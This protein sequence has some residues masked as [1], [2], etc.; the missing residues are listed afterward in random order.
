[1]INNLFLCIIVF[2]IVIYIIN[3][4]KNK[5]IFEKFNVNTPKIDPNFKI[6]SSKISYE[7]SVRFSKNK[8]YNQSRIVYGFND[9]NYFNKNIDN[10]FHIYGINDDK[11]KT[12][13]REKNDIVNKESDLNIDLSKLSESD[14]NYY[15][16]LIQI[17]ENEVGIGKDDN[18][19]THKIYILVGKNIFSLKKLKNDVYVESVYNDN[20]LLNKDEIQSYFGK[21]T[22]DIINKYIDFLKITDGPNLNSVIKK[23]IEI[24]EKHNLKQDA[25]GFRNYFDRDLTPNFKENYK[26][27]QDLQCFIRYD[28]NKMMGYNFSLYEKELKVSESKELLFNLLKELGCNVNGFDNWIKENK[29]LIITYISFI[30]T[31]EEN[32]VTIYYNN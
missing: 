3:S 24:S 22:F 6:D 23:M 5:N 16:S 1:M 27:I 2:S 7:R 15:N 20:Y 26:K 13:F 25:T 19:G 9:L 4:K 32:I 17:N 28:N 11:L 14:R 10:I 31:P 12:Y 21:E 30:K 18:M 29:D 8:N